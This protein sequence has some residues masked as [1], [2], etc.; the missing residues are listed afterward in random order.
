MRPTACLIWLPPRL[1]KVRYWYIE[2]CLSSSHWELL[3]V[4]YPLFESIVYRDCA[5]CCCE[6]YIQQLLISH[7]A[8]SQ[9]L[10]A[11]HEIE[12]LYNM[13]YSIWTYKKGMQKLW[14]RPFNLFCRFAKRTWEDAFFK[15]INVFTRPDMYNVV[16]VTICCYDSLSVLTACS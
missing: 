2:L 16:Y 15:R 12:P 4:G 5:K 8:L 6:T 1:L 3:E 11:E 9:V 13:W 14:V 7:K 10:H